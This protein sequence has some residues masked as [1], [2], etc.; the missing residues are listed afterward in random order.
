MHNG[1]IKFGGFFEGKNGKPDIPVL[2]IVTNGDNWEFGKLENT[3]FTENLLTYSLS[4][5]DTLYTILSLFF[6]ACQQNA[7]RL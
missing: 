7:L 2:G 5:L 4:S 1:K 6:D 3:A